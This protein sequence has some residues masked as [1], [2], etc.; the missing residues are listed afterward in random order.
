MT[1]VQYGATQSPTKRVFMT[2]TAA[3]SAGYPVCY[4]FDNVNT[5]QN[6]TDATIALST[7][8]DSRRICVEKPAYDNNLHFA[9][10]I[11]KDYPADTSGQWIEIFP[12]GSICNIKLA[13]S[14]ADAAPLVTAVAAASRNTGQILTFG[15]NKWYF[16]KAGFPGTGSATILQLMS[17]ANL[18]MAELQTGPQSGGYQEYLNYSGAVN[19]STVASVITRGGVTEVVSVIDGTAHGGA[20]SITASHLSLTAGDYIGQQK[21]IRVTTTV[22][23]SEGYLI[24][25]IAEAMQLHQ[26]TLPTATTVITAPV[27]IVAANQVSVPI[28][29]TFSHPNVDEY[30]KMTWNGD[31]W[32]VVGTALIAS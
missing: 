2:Y 28:T 12:P 23:Y 3:V 10:V 18:C 8:A 20:Q 4:D 25:S 19:A 14:I 6:I 7:A 13:A 1:Y 17:G 30:A 29:V 32:E 16:K 26:A 24:I 9:G 11:A 31:A 5:Y 15:V 22:A 27:P 21:L